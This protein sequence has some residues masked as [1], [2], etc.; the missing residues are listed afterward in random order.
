[1]FYI[2]YLYEVCVAALAKASLF[3]GH[4]RG[5][6]SNKEQNFFLCFFDITIKNLQYLDKGYFLDCVLSF[7]RSSMFLYKW[8][9]LH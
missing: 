8:N 4:Y 9:E 5:F 6:E 7:K 1:M 2:R 3:G